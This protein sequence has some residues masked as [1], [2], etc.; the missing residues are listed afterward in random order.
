MSHPCSI[1]AALP[2]PR[3][4]VEH[5]DR[6]VVGQDRAK[7]TLAVA[8]ANH[9]VRLLDVLD[10]ESAA[11][12]VTDAC[13]RQ[14]TIEKSNVL[15]IGPS[16]S[17]KTHLARALAECLDLPFV[18]ADATTLTEAGYVGEDVESIL[19]KLLVAAGGDVAEAQKGI[20]YIDEVDKLGGGRALGTK[21]LRLGVQHA[22]LKL[23]EGTV[24]NV[25]P[26]G[27]Y[28]MAG[29]TCVPFDTSQVLFI[30]GGAFVGLEDFVA[31]RLG[32]RA[33]GFDQAGSTVDDEATNPLRHV[34][35]EDVEGFGL[36]PELI[37]RLPVIATLDA[38]GVDDLVRILRGPQDALIG[39][40]RK[41]LMYRKARLDFTTGAIRAVAELA[42]QRGTGARGLRAIV[43][44]VLEPVLYDPEPWVS[45]TITEETV[46]GGPVEVFRFSDLCV[47][48]SAP[49]RHRMIGR[50]R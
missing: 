6:T 1:A 24:A 41:L 45:Y 12:T 37:G 31:R 17:G 5:L 42:H 23:I 14:V 10:R 9:Y 26:G 36:I 47:D 29:E 16:G 19:H 46:R 38:L 4:I 28:K 11:P 20:V 34:L 22:L 35:P 32:R 27:G 25:P 43:E 18:V 7:R 40:Y 49:L 21:D 48:E 33:F 50:A 30:C 15:L 8:V 3:R 13:L 2:T 44:R 39:Q